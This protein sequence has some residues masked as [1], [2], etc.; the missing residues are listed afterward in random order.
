MENYSFKEIKYTIYVYKLLGIVCFSAD[1]KEDFCRKLRNLLWYLPLCTLY[2]YMLWNGVNYF[3]QVHYTNNNEAVQVGDFILMY[4]SACNLITRIVCSIKNRNRLL[5]ILNQ[6]YSTKVITPKIHSKG[7]KQF[8]I[9]ISA[10]ILAIII[11]SITLGKDSDI[12]GQ[13][14]YYIQSLNNCIS[15]TENFF[16]YKI[17]NHIEIYM[18]TINREIV[19]CFNNGLSLRKQDTEASANSLLNVAQKHYKVINLAKLVNTLYGIPIALN[20]LSSFV[21]LISTVHYTTSSLVFFD[22]EDII[23][24]EFIFCSTIWS[25]SSFSQISLIII[26]WTSFCKEVSIVNLLKKIIKA[27]YY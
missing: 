26:T 17:L 15:F 16:I 27:G 2:I 4:V 12:N 1:G 22:A 3:W 13:S 19:G 11:G 8:F 21:F 25:T 7:V 6:I 20:A 10:E 18:L 9:L 24:Y 23:K 5:E 14:L